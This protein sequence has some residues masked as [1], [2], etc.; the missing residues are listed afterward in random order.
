MIKVDGSGSVEIKDSDF[1]RGSASAGAIQIGDLTVCC[2]KCGSGGIKIDGTLSVIKGV[3][4]LDGVLTCN[5]CGARSQG[6][7]A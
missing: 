6:T 5:S 1:G 3:P 4:T 2:P 7:L